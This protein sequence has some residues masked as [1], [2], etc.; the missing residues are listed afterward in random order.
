[1]NDE[2]KYLIRKGAYWY[3]PDGQGYTIDP[4]QAGRFTRAQAVQFTYP[5]GPDGP[6]DGLSYVLESEVP[7]ANPTA[8]Q[9]D[10][11][12]EA[13]R[14]F[15]RLRLPKKPQGNASFYSIY[16]KHIE[17]ARAALA[18]QEASDG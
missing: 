9:Y 17:A 4:E 3:R 6:R 5:N 8:S 2:P 15:A 13:L 14:P 7:G 18:S 1:M 12:I 11:L 10:K 16:H